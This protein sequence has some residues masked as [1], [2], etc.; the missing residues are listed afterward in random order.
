[1]TPN[2]GP[3]LRLAPSIILP[4]KKR[5]V[6]LG[7]FTLALFIM[8]TEMLFKMPPQ[9]L[10][11]LCL[12]QT[13]PHALEERHAEPIVRTGKHAMHR[14]LA[15]PGGHDFESLADVDDERTGD[16]GDVDPFAVAVE[17]LQ[18]FGFR[19]RCLQEECPP[20]G[21]VFVGAYALTIV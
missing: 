1:M 8:A 2:L 13:A 4:S 7:L 17:G 12:G 9:R 5:R 15:D 3:K 10:H 6:D 21:G 14:R 16:G 19:G 18:A 20:S 11:R